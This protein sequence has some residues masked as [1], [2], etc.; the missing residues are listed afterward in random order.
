MMSPGSQAEAERDQK[1]VLAFLARPSSYEPAP[2]AVERIDTH[3]AIVFLAGDFA[4]KVKRAVTLPYLD[5]SRLEMREAVCRREIEVN[6]RTAPD[7]YLGVVAITRGRDG[8]LAIGGKGEPVE[9]VV[10]MRRFDQSKLLDGLAEKGDLPVATMRPLA[11]KIAGLHAQARANRHL[12]Y[13]AAMARDVI[14]PVSKAAKKAP[15]LIG[16]NEAEGFVRAFHEELRRGRTLLERRA[17]QGYVRR[18]HGD[19]HLRNIVMIDDAPVLFDAIEFDENIATI[20]ILYDLAFLLMDLWHR[21]LPAH[22][23]AVFNE[24]MRRPEAGGPLAALE[25]LRLLPLY[26]AARAGVRAMVALDRL[27]VVEGREQDKAEREFVEF[28]GLASGFLETQPPGL[29]AVGGLSGTGKT[30]LARTLAPFVGDAP[31][32]LVVRS[33]VERK[34][35]AGVDETEKLSPEHYKKKATGLVYRACFAK[36]EAALA[37]GHSVILDAVFARQDQ[38]E[39]ARQIADKTGVSFTGIWLE[40]PEQEL[41]ERVERRSGDASDADARVVRRQLDYDLGGIDWMR[42]DAGGN[43][44]AL[45]R[46]V[47][48]RLGLEPFSP[49]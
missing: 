6:R 2:R 25:G 24:Y 26:L 47:R 31:G 9:W 40:A 49:R 11:E 41:V 3:A 4:Y 46:D 5:F 19:L 1:E 35:L 38:R 33:D 34:R 14:D 18:C 21:N 30:T 17:R 45:Y 37:A 12:D 15:P 8:A 36:A 20:D 48:R 16:K 32:A 42:V 23:N 43:A 22:A 29:L 13:A 28:F 44:G 10:K 27:A 39:R 7:I